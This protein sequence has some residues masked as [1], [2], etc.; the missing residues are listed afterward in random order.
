M[1]LV[2]TL[3]G[4]RHR[5][6]SSGSFKVRQYVINRFVN[7]TSQSIEV[8]QTLN[9]WF[10]THMNLIHKFPDNVGWFGDG[11]ICLGETGYM[12]AQHGDWQSMRCRTG[13]AYIDPNCCG[14]ICITNYMLLVLRHLG[15]TGI[16]S[17]KPINIVANNM[18][19]I[20]RKDMRMNPRAGIVTSL[21]ELRI[22]MGSLT[23]LQ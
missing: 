5:T 7:Y 11:S 17:D 3:Q 21:Y 23:S 6:S 13:K 1:I 14:C 22:A 18:L 19:M 16:Q 12:L 15:S 10:R 2:A 9:V 20:D 8:R 4:V